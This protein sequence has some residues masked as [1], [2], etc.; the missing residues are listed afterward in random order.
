MTS[1][2]ILCAGTVKDVDLEFYGCRKQ[3]VKVTD[4]ERVIDRTIRLIKQY[5][6]DFKIYII[7]TTKDFLIPRTILFLVNNNL[8]SNI[9][10]RIRQTKNFWS[11]KTVILY[12]D[13]WYSEDCIKKVSNYSGPLMF[14]GRSKP[15][16]ITGKDHGEPYAI[17]WLQNE[18]SVILKN[19]ERVFTLANKGKT[20]S[21]LCRDFE[22]FNSHHKRPFSFSYLGVMDSSIWTEIDDFTD[23][24][25]IP[26]NYNDWMKRYKYW[27]ETG[28]HLYL[29]K[30]DTE[31]TKE[32]SVEV[33]KENLEQVCNDVSSEEDYVI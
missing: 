11:H 13:V 9:L 27:L 10:S 32:I 23:D 21:R 30:D 7:A 16:E 12:G 20:P 18:N 28:S 17:C 25:D 5:N 3:F 31:E 2:I 22:L 19:I 4:N 29:V 8:V 1:F 15:S 14:F 6:S 24:F 26:C 33:F